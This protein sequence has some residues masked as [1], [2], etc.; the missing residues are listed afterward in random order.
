MGVWNENN[1]HT[2]SADFMALISNNMFQEFILPEI[3]E[4]V[5]WLDASIFHLDGPA[6][7]N[8]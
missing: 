8:I 7:L 2:I 4:E 5:N 1:W 3:H 6:T